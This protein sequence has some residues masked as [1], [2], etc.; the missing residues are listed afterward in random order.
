[1]RRLIRKPTTN[2]NNDVGPTGPANSIPAENNEV[3]DRLKNAD[4]TFPT[5]N[6]SSNNQI[7]QDSQEEITEAVDN[8]PTETEISIPLFETSLF[9]DTIT[10]L[11]EST[12]NVPR[13]KTP[14]GPQQFPPL[15]LSDDA[16]GNINRFKGNL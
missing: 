15:D 13:M 5:V 11:E 14:E 3:E 4:A 12:P 6:E 7:S 2:Q 8:T 10:Q 1:M 9:H 16:F